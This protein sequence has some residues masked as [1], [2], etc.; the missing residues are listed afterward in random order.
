MKENKYTRLSQLV[1]RERIQKH[2]FELEL[3]LF[4]QGHLD[5]FL[6][7]DYFKE[8]YG[9]NKYLFYLLIRS[10]SIKTFIENIGDF[11]LK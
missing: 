3:D 11:I 10:I 8:G 1:I 2:I 9:L 5:Y 4:C 6:R 7:E